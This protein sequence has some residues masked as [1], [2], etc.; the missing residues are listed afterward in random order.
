MIFFGTSVHSFSGARM[1]FSACGDREFR[2][3]GFHPQR[4]G[5]G[6]IGLD[7]RHRVLKRGDE[8]L[9]DFAVLVV[10]FV[11]VHTELNVCGPPS[12]S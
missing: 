6:R 3:L 8:G 12:T 5:A 9:H 11:E 10:V 7:L 4:G 1:I 2:I